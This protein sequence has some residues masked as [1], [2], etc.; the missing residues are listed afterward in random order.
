MTFL[1]DGAVRVIHGDCIEVMASL[2]AGSVHAIVTDPPY[3]LTAGKK[4]GSGEASLN[5][6]SPYGRSRIGTGGG[7]MGQE[8]DS[9]GVAFDPATWRAAL[10]VLAPGGYLVAFGGTRTAHRMVCA[11]EDAGFEIRDTLAWLY[12]SG[13]PKS[14][15]V[16]KAI[17]KAA[18]VEREVVG[19]SEHASGIAD[20]NAGPQSR[21]T[22]FAWANGKSVAAH[23]PITA[24]ATEDAKAWQG[25][26]TALKPAHEPITLAR[27]PLV[28]TVA[29]NVLEHGTGALNID[30]CRIASDDLNPSLRIREAAL[31]NGRAPTDPGAPDGTGG[32]PTG[33]VN[34]TSLDS[35]AAPRE[36]EATGRWPANVILDEEAARLLDEQTGELHSQDPATRGNRPTTSIFGGTGEH[37]NGGGVGDKGGASRFF[38]CAKASSAERNA[39]LDGFAETASAK[40]GAG[41]RSSVGRPAEGSTMSEDRTARNSHPTVKPVDLMRWLVRLVAPLGGVV[42]DP[43]MG[44]GTTGIACV[45]EGVRFVGIEREAEYLPIAEA[46]IRHAEKRHARGLPFVDPDPMTERPLDGQLDLLGAFATEAIDTPKGEA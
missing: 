11:I 33:W 37:V 40:L 4:G 32:G 36:G 27:K 22:D 38:Y 43:F 31:R 1:D 8:W 45:L 30:A 17:D 34:R 24:P 25:W 29:A 20:G 12:G 16:S 39:G 28:G 26:G 3:D 21:D 6:D 23:Y 44:S 35:F 18:G 10:R 14:L 7:F 2:P 13:F 41:M 5:L 19:M 9:T 46:R 42:L 15:D